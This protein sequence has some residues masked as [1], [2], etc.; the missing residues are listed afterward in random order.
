MPLL[1]IL[2]YLDSI[3][4]EFTIEVPKK[5]KS[6]GTKLKAPENLSEAVPTKT[7][8]SETSYTKSVQ[9]SLPMISI[10]NDAIEKGFTSK[11]MPSEFIY[12]TTALKGYVKKTAP[13]Y[14]LAPIYQEVLTFNKGLKG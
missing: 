14:L 11:N 3:P 2:I 8:L 13:N 6:T 4:E 10:V 7:P 9:A 1:S 12:K 5:K